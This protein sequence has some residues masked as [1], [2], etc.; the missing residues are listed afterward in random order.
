MGTLT[1]LLESL[2]TSFSLQMSHEK[3]GRYE[4]LLHRY[5]LC[6]R[7]SGRDQ[8]QRGVVRGGELDS[9]GLP[10]VSHDLEGTRRSVL[11]VR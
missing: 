7:W 3:S 1:D 2:L 11:L 6:L 9:N 5:T 8:L 4:S 10:V